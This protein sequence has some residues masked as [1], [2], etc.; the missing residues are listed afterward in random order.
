MRMPKWTLTPTV[1]CWLVGLG[2]PAFWG[3]IS[4]FIKPSPAGGENRN[5]KI[6]QTT[7]SHS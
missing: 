3:S 4:V 5:D 1:E 2:L 6:V 7:P